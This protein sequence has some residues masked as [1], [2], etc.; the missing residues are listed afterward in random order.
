MALVCGPQIILWLY[1]SIRAN[2]PLLSPLLWFITWSPKCLHLN[3]VFLSLIFWVQI[4]LSTGG[5]KSI[6]GTEQGANAF[7]FYISSSL[8]QVSNSPSLSISPSFSNFKANRLSILRGSKY[9][10]KL[11]RTFGLIWMNKEALFPHKASSSA[12]QNTSL[13]NLREIMA[14]DGHISFLK[15]PSRLLTRLY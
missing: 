10:Q 1:I 8:L 13:R 7:P 11:C 4:F 6:W 14:Q 3:W 9:R 12:Q 5:S 15:W 2:V